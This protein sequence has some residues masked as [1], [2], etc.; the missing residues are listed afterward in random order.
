[1]ELRSDIRPI[2]GT[3]RTYAGLA[4]QR[5]REMVLDGHLAP[6][7]R[8]NEV[9]IAAALKISRGPVREGIQ[10]LVAQGLLARRDH[11]GSYVREFDEIEL[12]HL[13]EVRIAL[14][15][16]AVRVAATKTTK[17]Q[18]ASLAQLLSATGRRMG[19]ADPKPYPSDL[20]FHRGLAA[21]SNNPAL[22]E[23]H[24]HALQQVELARSRSARDPDRARAAFTEHKEI[25][26]A[27]VAGD[28]RLAEETLERHL[29]DS[30]RNAVALL[31]TAAL[32]SKD[33]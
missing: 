15:T 25:V 19:R 14:E 21:L 1:M 32:P 17:E 16:R 20:D 29:W 23:M 9:E 8:V 26:S 28:S 7:A 11:Y 13:Y 33:R 3:K 31:V 27:L 18:V 22:I 10:R 12:E 30:Y 2:G 24:S 6:G 5:L 4:E